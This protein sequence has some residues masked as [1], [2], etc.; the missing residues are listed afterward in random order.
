MNTCLNYYPSIK[1]SGGEW[2]A[3]NGIHRGNE[4]KI[5]K[6][7]PSPPGLTA[8]KEL[9]DPPPLCRGYY[10][11]WL[12]VLDR[13]T[14]ERFSPLKC[15]LRPAKSGERRLTDPRLKTPGVGAGC[16][17]LY[18]YWP[19]TALNSLTMKRGR[20]TDNAGICRITCT[21]GSARPEDRRETWRAVRSPLFRPGVGISRSNRLLVF[22]PTHG[23]LWTNIKNRAPKTAW[24]AVTGT[25]DEYS[26]V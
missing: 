7:K 23:F 2:W 19:P 25:R 4:K 18:C 15:K 9:F 26:G 24:T 20:R 12:T 8:L 17:S 6:K 14:N 1:V 11:F 22:F 21:T 16:S 5:E 3:W 13:G 10:N